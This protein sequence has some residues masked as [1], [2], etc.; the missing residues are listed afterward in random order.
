MWKPR[1][2]ANGDDGTVER[3]TGVSPTEAS[4]ASVIARPGPREPDLGR[5]RALPAVLLAPTLAGIGAWMWSRSQPGSGFWLLIGAFWLL[6]AAGACW[7][8]F[9]VLWLADRRRRRP[10]RVPVWSLVAA[11]VLVV[12]ATVLAVADVPL[13][14]RWAVSEGA[15]DGA[16]QA[17]APTGTS[18]DGPIDVPGRLGAYRI[19]GAERVGTAVLFETEGAAGFFVRSGFAHVPAGLAS[20]PERTA[21]GASFDPLGDDW[22]AWII[23]D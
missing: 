14:L 15:F 23:H 4:P 8:V 5:S 22:Y 13:R 16:V 7:V 19:A 20:L 6:L 11:A 1:P 3:A 12:S 21:G 10:P 9:A 18:Q 2:V 17:A